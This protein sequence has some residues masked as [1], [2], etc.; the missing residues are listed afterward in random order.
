[1][2]ESFTTIEAIYY[3][4]KKVGSADKLKIVKLIYLVDK[5]HLFHYGRAVTDGNYFAMEY[6]PVNSTVK[7]ILNFNDFN[8]YKDEMDYANRLIKKV[9][10]HDFEAKSVNNFVF[11]HL[12]ET[13]QE[14]LDYVCEKFGKWG[15]NKLLKYTHKY[16]EWKKHE[17]KLKSGSRR[18]DIKTVE[19]FSKIDEIFNVSDGHLEESKAMFLGDF[20]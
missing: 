16:P 1:M 7:D 5:Y 17:E 4:L 3:L 11:G 2:K 6:G 13:D 10:P 19:L 12:S 18:E 20:V 9:R 8:M 15:T 14:A